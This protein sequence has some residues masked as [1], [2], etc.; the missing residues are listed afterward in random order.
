MFWTAEVKNIYQF[1]GAQKIFSP[2][3]TCSK[4]RTKTLE[5]GVKYV[6]N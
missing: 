6:Q 3:F 1:K 4:S 2:T 5:K